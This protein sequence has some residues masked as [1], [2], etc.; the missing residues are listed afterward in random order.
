MAVLVNPCRQI[1][2]CL[3]IQFGIKDIYTYIYT[4]IYI[5]V[6]MYVAAFICYTLHV[7]RIFA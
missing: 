1:W 5:Y 3:R 6:Y 2:V 4:Y 7:R